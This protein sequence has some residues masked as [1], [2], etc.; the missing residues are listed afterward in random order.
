M[1]KGENSRGA[2]MVEAAMVFP[3]LILLVMATLE[4][5]LVFKDFL[6]ISYI[7][8][9]GARVGG[10]AGDDLDADCAILRGIGTIA[11]APDLER[12]SEVQIFKADV[13]GNQGLTNVAHFVP[14]GD[15]R[16]CTVPSAPGDGWEFDSITWPPTSRQ[17]T[18][19]DPD[20][21]I[22]GV[23]V[24]MSRDWVTGFPPFRGSIQIDESTITRLEP[25]AF[26]ID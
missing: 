19:G 13:N 9:E 12:I 8:R 3:I 14:G 17:T 18:V 15:P 5:G 4:I 10:I 21:D 25:E 23:R 22:I 7:S 26:D 6:T 20:L 11:T 2:T 16:A 24:V 1:G